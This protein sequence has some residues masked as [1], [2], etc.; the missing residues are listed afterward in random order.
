MANTLTSDRIPAECLSG[1]LAGVWSGWMGL[2]DREIVREA[3]A[4][5]IHINLAYKFLENR[6]H[7]SS[8][9]AKAFFSNEVEIW[10]SSL[11]KKRQVHR[12]SHIL[13]N[14]VSFII[15]LNGQHAQLINQSN[16]FNFRG[17]FL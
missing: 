3:S 16:I 15:L 4:K 11:L 12:A 14:V 2:G 8:Q 6:R 10:V 9:E 5:G 17:K 7:C 13:K 1:E